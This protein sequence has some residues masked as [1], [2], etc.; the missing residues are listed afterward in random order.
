MEERYFEELQRMVDEN[1]S[2][3]NIETTVT[4]RFQSAPWLTTIQNMDILLAGVG[5]IGSWTALLLAR[6]NPRNLVLMDMDRVDKSN[7]SGQLYSKDDIDNYK[8]DSINRTLQNYANY[9][10]G[11]AIRFP[12]TE[13]SEAYKVMI[14]G[15]DNMKARKTY[16]KK[17]VELVKNTPEEER[18][19]CLYVDGRLN[20]EK[21][22][23]LSITGDDYASMKK[24]AQEYLFNDSE[25]PHQLCSFKQTTYCAAMIASVICNSVVN[26]A[27]HN[28]ARPVIF[29]QE[30]DAE[31][32]FLTQES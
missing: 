10:R 29:F 18:C 23:V 3:P 17:W 7:L 30:Y 25:A 8:V 28:I 11:M 31:S 12:F 24:Y 20:A 6:M 1:N 9:Y 13:E 32:L 22:Q 2:Y 5:G 16:F 26:F 21:F 19:N 4:D 14:C 27:S 15:F